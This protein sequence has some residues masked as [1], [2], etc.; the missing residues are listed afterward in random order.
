MVSPIV[1][2]PP[3]E[4]K[5][6]DCR[7][8]SWILTLHVLKQPFQLVAITKHEPSNVVHV[9][10]RL[11]FCI[12]VVLLE[13]F[14]VVRVSFC[15]ILKGIKQVNYLL[16][17]LYIRCDL[18]LSRRE[19]LLKRVLI[20]KPHLYYLRLILPKFDRALLSAYWSLFRITRFVGHIR[21]LVAAHLHNA[22]LVLIKVLEVSPHNLR[23]LAILHRDEGADFRIRKDVETLDQ[24]VHVISKCLSPFLYHLRALVLE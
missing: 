20:P 1:K 11:Q 19:T 2:K 9:D 6:L 18:G 10:D 17:T 14:N 21:N 24:F 23:V 15:I 22:F 12:Q 3:N 13:D 16:L 7:Y 8:R 5:K 4:V